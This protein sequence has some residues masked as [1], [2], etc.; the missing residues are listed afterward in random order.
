MNLYFGHPDNPTQL[1]RWLRTARRWLEN[2]D[3]VV[4]L[5][6]PCSP[7]DI[8]AAI[9]VA[10]RGGWHCFAREQREREGEAII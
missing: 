5:P 4:G 10:W 8:I 1:R 9:E 7:G 2:D 6:D 3:S